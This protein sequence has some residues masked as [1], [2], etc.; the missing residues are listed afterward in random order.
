MSRVELSPLFNECGCVAAC[1]RGC[2]RGQ[3]C[4]SSLLGPTSTPTSPPPSP[5]PSAPSSVAAASVAAPA[6]LSSATGPH[7]GT[8]SPTAGQWTCHACARRHNNDSD[9]ACSI[10]HTVRNRAEEARI[11]FSRVAKSNR[12]ELMR[13]NSALMT[14]RPGDW[15]C[16]ACRWV[17]T[18]SA[19]LCVRVCVFGWQPVLSPTSC[20]PCLR[21][22]QARW[23]PS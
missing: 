20:G 8:G 1:V 7:I 2:V 14:P 19:N 17:R 9:V 10:C 13:Q 5:P 15:T 12:G 11:A 3:G 21:G 22:A 23:E 16:T 6:P 4:S 18:R